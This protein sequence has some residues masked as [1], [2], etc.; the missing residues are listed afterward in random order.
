MTETE[1]MRVLLTHW[2]EHNQEHAAEYRRWA[3]NASKISH[4]LLAAA[5]SLLLVNQALIRALKKLGGPMD[6]Q[7]IHDRVVCGSSES[8]NTHRK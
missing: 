3:K 5:E 8:R 7:H 6:I 2:I 4:D 1:I